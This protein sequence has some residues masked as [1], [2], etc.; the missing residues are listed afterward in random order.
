MKEGNMKEDLFSHVF[1]VK[2][3]EIKKD[4]CEVCGQGTVI[5]CPDRDTANH[6]VHTVN[7][8]ALIF[9]ADRILIIIKAGFI[10]SLSALILGLL[11]ERFI[12]YSA[13]SHLLFAWLSIVYGSTYALCVGNFYLASYLNEKWKLKKEINYL[14][15]ES[16]TKGK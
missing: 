10:F 12:D 1:L 4:T 14:I 13:E 15:Q 8:Q 3:N 5:R 7:Q 6:I 2:L 11:F 16:P 9:K